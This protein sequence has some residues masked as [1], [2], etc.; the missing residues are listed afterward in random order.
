MTRVVLVVCFLIAFAA[1][2]AVGFQ[3]RRPGPPPGD[4]RDRHSGWLA[5]ELNLTAQQQEQLRAIWSETAMRGGREREDGHKEC[6]KDRDAEIARLIRP[7]DRPQYEEIMRKHADRKAA[8]D[9]EW[10]AAFD[11]AVEKTR[12][13]LTPEQRIKYETLLKRHEADR[14]L[15]DRHRGDR[16]ERDIRRGDRRPMSRP[17]SQP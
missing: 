4:R 14:S 15:H 10:R 17:S 3:S 16:D 9:R 12:Q 2:L 6:S 11:A 8:L 13:I 7:E 1:G 5:G